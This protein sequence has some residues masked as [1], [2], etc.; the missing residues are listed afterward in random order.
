MIQRWPEI[1][2][3]STRSLAVFENLIPWPVVWFSMAVAGFLCIVFVTIPL[4]VFVG[5]PRRRER[6]MEREL[7][8]F[9]NIMD[10][11]DPQFD[12]YS[13]DEQ[14]EALVAYRANLGS[15]KR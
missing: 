9:L 13:F 2:A 4:L 8:A 11:M 6:E 15:R 14:L 5:W 10:E 1:S 3:S 12:C 7:D